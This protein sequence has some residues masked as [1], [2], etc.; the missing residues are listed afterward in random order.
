MKNLLTIG[1]IL[2]FI[3]MSI[4]SSTG[5]NVR[6]HS[7][8]TSSNGKT[9]Y[10]GGSGPSNYTKIQDAIDDASDGDTVFVYNGMYW[11]NVL[12]DKTINL[13][14]E[15]RNNTC[16]L[17]KYDA[18]IYVTADLVN[19]SGFSICWGDVGIELCSNYNIITGNKIHIFRN[20]GININSSSNNITGNNISGGKIGI[21]IYTSYNIVS[22]NDIF[23]SSRYG[24][25][26]ASSS[27]NNDIIG[28]N[29]SYNWINWWG[30][31]M[32]V[33]K[34]NSNNI[35]RNNISYNW[36]RG[37][38]LDSSNN[39]SIIDNVISDNGKWMDN[40]ESKGGVILSNS[41]NNTI[42]ENIFYNDSIGIYLINSNI[43]N[44]IKDNYFSC[45]GD[46]IIT[47]LSCGNYIVNNTIIDNGHTIGLS[48]SCNNTISCNKLYNDARCTTLRLYYSN[49]NV[50][51]KNNIVLCGGI[52]I[53]HSIN[54]TINRNMVS[55]CS[56]GITLWDAS[57]N[58]MIYNNLSN[59][60]FY[61]LWAGS[62]YNDYCEEY[63]N[64]YSCYKIDNI[65]IITLDNKSSTIIS[66]NNAI[67]HNNFINNSNNSYD[68][69]N[70][71]WD[72]G[73]Y[74]N[75]WDDLKERYPDANKK[76]LK[77][78]WDTPYEIP[79]G[80]STDRYPLIKQWPDPV[81]KISSDSHNE[82]YKRWI[83]RFPLLY[84]FI[85]RIKERWSI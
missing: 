69:F 62:Y 68:E 47:R 50:I 53:S 35:I 30:A 84:Q 46:A 56:Y 15:D 4:S 21:K 67:Y 9:L 76:R 61:G 38:Y 57:Y 41:S 71:T 59:S 8:N 32:L 39:N 51:R 79:S 44:I 60:R 65:D 5:F 58:T 75:Y 81:S 78:I 22:K 64:H 49:N 24:I 54:N 82:M 20:I 27:H 77:G 12:V 74:G 43:S 17:E 73:K 63:H 55:N 34:S 3:G 70:N 18:I 14:G 40:Y 7:N 25:K 2:L 28:N 6:E 72:D 26:L 16:I 37:I 10:V 85:M 52:D 83:G 36:N 33:S 19:I 66:S 45:N 31:G 1:I 42:A 48:K 13:I 80:N 23:Y 29:I 11:E